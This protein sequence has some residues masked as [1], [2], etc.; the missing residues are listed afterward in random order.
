MFMNQIWRPSAA[1]QYVIY[2]AHIIPSKES[3]VWYTDDSAFQRSS[4][5]H[6]MADAHDAILAKSV[7]LIRREKP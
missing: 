5:L 1:S 6:G 3:R 4:S 7:K 2:R